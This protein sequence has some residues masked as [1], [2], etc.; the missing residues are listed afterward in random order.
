MK[1]M[2]THS[3]VD[4]DLDETENRFDMPCQIIINFYD[5]FQEEKSDALN[6]IFD[7][8]YFKTVSLSW[9]YSIQYWYNQ[10]LN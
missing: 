10:Q 4:V 1:N 8:I 2:Y 7:A 9:Q 6:W 5:S 3:M